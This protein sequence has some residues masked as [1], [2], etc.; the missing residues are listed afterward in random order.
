MLG[1][2][3]IFL[4]TSSRT[5][6]WL[7]SASLASDGKYARLPELNGGRVTAAWTTLAPGCPLALV[8]A[9]FNTGE[10]PTSLGNTTI[11]DEIAILISEGGIPFL[12]AGDWQV[13][14][15]AISTTARRS[16][17]PK[18]RG[19][20]ASARRGEDLTGTSAAKNGFRLGPIP[21]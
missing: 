16:I 19:A 9:Y 12:I 20:R 10:P 5:F 6:A 11:R 17:E 1:T 13:P 18:G 15:E 4:W 3:Q 8:E 14:P 7:Q 2:H 21:L